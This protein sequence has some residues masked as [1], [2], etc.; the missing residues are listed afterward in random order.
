[1]GL[2]VRGKK[3]EE[4]EEEEGGIGKRAYGARAMGSIP[5]LFISP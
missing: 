1:M 2:V 5:V 4:E 3:E